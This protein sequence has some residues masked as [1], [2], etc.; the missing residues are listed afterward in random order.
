[1]AEDG[2]VMAGRSHRLLLMVALASV[3]L[4]VGSVAGAAGDHAVSFASPALLAA[5]PTPAGIAI[6]DL[7]GDGKPDLAVANG[8]VDPDEGQVGTVSIRLNRGDGTFKPRRDY[9][10]TPGPA[11][12]AIADLNRD[13]K[14]DL[15]T[16]NFDGS[17]STLFNSGDGSFRVEHDYPTGDRTASIAVADVN[18][19][20]APDL[21]ATVADNNA[22]DVLLNDGEGGFKQ[23]A[24]Y[25]TGPSPWDVAAGDLNGDG[26]TDLAV[27]D[28]SSSNSVTILLND[29]HGAFG[30]RHEYAAGSQPLSVAIA[31]LNG[32]GTPD[33]AVSHFGGVGHSNSVS[34]LRNDGHGR[35]PSRRTYPVAEGGGPVAVGDLSGDGKPDV[36]TVHD[37]SDRLSLLVNN[38][39]GVLLPVL[40]YPTGQLP[41][42]VAIGDLNGDGRADLVSADSWED[43]SNDLTVI[44]SHPGR[45]DVQNLVKLTIA[46]ARAKLAR[47]G[48]RLGAVGTAYSKSV[49]KGL[50]MRQRPLFGSVLSGGAKVSVVL[51]KGKR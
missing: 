12:I 1:M 15:A 11:A 31:D 2:L 23:R 43:V 32:D 24:A 14:P 34:V 6:G 19:D 28:F 27:A 45:C 41:Q 48:C 42:A 35:F 46:T 25:T 47:S 21:V 51:S 3:S 5:T 36:V 9:E 38:G 17:V 33:L 18:G 44:L 8:S 16:A 30:S 40:A 49:A 26:A 50:V 13:G 7:N 4:A 29:G 10:D 20:G 37:D 39:K 22:V